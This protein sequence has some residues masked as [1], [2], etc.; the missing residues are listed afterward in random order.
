MVDFTVRAGHS[1]AKYAGIE[2]AE[3]L[4]VDLGRDFPVGA[5]RIAVPGSVTDQK[6]LIA[7]D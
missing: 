2:R 7:V 4:R 5:T 6:V 3:R 1:A